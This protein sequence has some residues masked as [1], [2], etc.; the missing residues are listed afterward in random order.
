MKDENHFE[1]MYRGKKIK[2]YLPD[3]DD[4]IQKK[5]IKTRNFY[6]VLMLED[7]K[8]K[9]PPNSVFVDAGAN[10]GNHTIYF[11]N[12][13]DAKK[14]YSFE[15][16]KDLCKVMIRNLEIN[17]AIDNVE[18]YGCALGDGLYKVD[19]NIKNK[20][21]LAMSH[22]GQSTKIT[23]NVYPMDYAL[24]DRVRKIH[25]IKIDVGGVEMEVLN[26]SKKIIQRDSPVLYIQTYTDAKYR[27]IFE[28]LSYYRYQLVGQYNIPPS[29]VFIR[30]N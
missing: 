16:R 24:F 14:I 6:E 23:T 7:I 26:G 10:I 2:F 1:F 30:A 21:K 15:P 20:K 18:L 27:D 25:L 13:C 19:I 12:I 28:F 11:S 3:R 8:R 17:K 9:I 22:A 29:Y 4:T 5:I